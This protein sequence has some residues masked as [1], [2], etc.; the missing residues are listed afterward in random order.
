MNKD[1]MC[2]DH[3]SKRT[4]G[5][6]CVRAV[7]R[8]GSNFCVPGLDEENSYFKAPVDY[9]FGKGEHGSELVM[10]CATGY[11]LIYGHAACADGRCR[12]TGVKSDLQSEN[13]FCYDGQLVSL[14]YL[15][16]GRL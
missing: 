2:V 13:I 15:P 7:C 11:S 4:R 8:P 12:Y 5:E 10:R 16:R 3:L 14:N 6:T 1:L 9:R